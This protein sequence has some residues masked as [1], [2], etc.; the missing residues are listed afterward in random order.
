MKSEE[1]IVIYDNGVQETVKD[2]LINK[3]ITI[4]HLNDYKIDYIKEER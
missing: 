2:A 4:N 1:V 3:R